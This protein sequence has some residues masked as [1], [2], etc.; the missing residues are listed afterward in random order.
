MG[1]PHL[2]RRSFLTA[3]SAGAV[4]VTAAPMLAACGGDDSGSDGKVTIEWMNI[5]TTEPSQ[6]LFPKIAKAYE[7]QNPNV[8]IKAT[9]LENDAYKSKMTALVAS[10][11]L[12]DIYVTWGG[13]VLKQQ[14]DAG[15]V[16]DITSDGSKVLGTMTDVSKKAYQFD[17][18]TYAVPYD[19]GMVGFWYNKK[20]FE[21]AGISGPPKTWTE[22]LD[23]VRK[24]KDAGVTPIA[25][26]GKDKWPGHY[27]W[28][29][30]SMRIA[31]MAAMEQAAQSN[32]FGG[33]PF[34]QAGERLKELADLQ[35]FQKGFQNAGFDT[36]GGQAATMGAGKAGMS[37]MGQWAPSV[38][39]DASGN[40][41]G[42]DLGW[43]PFP[44]VEGGPGAV[45]D[46]FGGGNGH[47]V[48]KDAPPEAVDFLTF[49]MN[50]QNEREFVTSG[51]FMP[52][53]KGA[54]SALEDEN[55]KMVASALNGSSGFQLYL[56]QAFPPAVGQEVN[57]SVASLIAGKK[58][59][60]EVAQSVTK[61]AKSQ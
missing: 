11:D 35:P 25:L 61:V 29:Y 37:L 43:F 1:I 22:F 31:G 58:S 15:L 9:S 34:V 28:A 20:H 19:M 45:T 23:A 18:K 51:A 55:R 32:D 13:G 40:D 26:G 38:Q 44:T 7:A 24:L 21:K 42:D 54:E 53:V 10:G 50:E 47:A 56:D 4:L 33:A 36:P 59:A 2:P 8:D 14:V 16:K 46:V 6:S 5:A 57:D 60:Q 39:K 12:P 17:G 49:L 41:L 27:Y 48:S 3:V 30:L 52:V